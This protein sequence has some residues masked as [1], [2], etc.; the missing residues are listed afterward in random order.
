M[1]ND[2][3]EYGEEAQAAAAWWA[4]MLRG[5]SFRHDVGDEDLNEWLDV[6]RA[7]TDTAY[8]EEELEAFE[9]TLAQYVHDALE[10]KLERYDETFPDSDNTIGRAL[11]FGVD[12]HPNT[13]LEAA[14]VE[15]G[16]DYNRFTTFKAK[17]H[18]WVQPG[19]VSVR[20]GYQQ[21]EEVIYREE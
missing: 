9:E 17:T 4:D 5:P 3:G 13:L 6:A 14:A 2:L 11:S 7:V 10:E 21:P 18:M 19:E 15:A 12:Y 1:T 20:P 8:S 16:L